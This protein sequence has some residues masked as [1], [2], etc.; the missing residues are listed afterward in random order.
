MKYHIILTIT[1]PLYIPVVLHKLSNNIWDT[2][3]CT[4]YGSET[5]LGFPTIQVY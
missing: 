1:T 4:R 2:E 5:S 3:V